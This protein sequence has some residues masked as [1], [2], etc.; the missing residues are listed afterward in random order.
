MRT[1]RPFRPDPLALAVGALASYRLTMLVTS[2]TITEPLRARA[3]A[4]V[5]QRRSTE[6]LAAGLECPWCAGLWVAVPATAAT[7]AWS[8]RR[9]WWLAAGSLAASA[10]TG[11]VS[12]YAAPND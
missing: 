3:V 5:E 1:N 11:I 8:H 10:V 4:L 7:L 2:D 9:A 12:R 6:K